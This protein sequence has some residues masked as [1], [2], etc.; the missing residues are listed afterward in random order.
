[1]GNLS[2][3]FLQTDRF[4]APGQIV[5]VYSGQNMKSPFF[6][7][8]MSNFFHIEESTPSNKNLITFEA[9]GLAM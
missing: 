6:L 7:Q 3:G 9:L 1:M 8:N 4:S 5:G 2:F